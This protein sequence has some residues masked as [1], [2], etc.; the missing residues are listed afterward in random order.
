LLKHPEK[1]INNTVLN[2]LYLHG[3]AS[4]P[5]SRKAKFFQGKIEGESWRYIAPDLNVPTFEQLSMASQIEL[6]Q[7]SA[8]QFG[9]GPLILVGSSMGGLLAALLEGK[10][11]NV[12]ALILLAPG[13]G[14][15]RRWP[16]IIG[17][18]GMDAWQETGA[19]QFF[20]YGANAEKA[21][22][23]TFTHELQKIQT[24]NFQV[25]TP[26][27]VFHGVND[28]TVPLEHSKVFA[29]ANEKLVELVQLNDNHELAQALDQIW[30]DSMTFLQKHNIAPRTASDTS[31]R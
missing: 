19:R 11:A 29:A 4:S 27:I 20:H 1:L 16:Q 21:L 5:A 7:A 30:H 10:I 15:T 22:H 25:N 28:E 14:I 12:A 17:G 9:P 3:F 31:H 2:F 18:E 13:F 23:F 24:E 6:A 8:G 26:T